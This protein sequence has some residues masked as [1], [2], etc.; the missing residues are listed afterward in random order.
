MVILSFLLGC[1]PKAIYFP[2]L[3]LMLFVPK[4][5]FGT[6]Y[7]TK[8]LAYRAA[9]LGASAL[10]LASFAAPFLFGSSGSGD[11]RGGDGVDS[12]GQV[13]WILENPLSFVSIMGSFLK[14]YLSPSVSGGY[15]DSLAYLS[16][17][18]LGGVPLVVLIIASIVDSNEKAFLYSGAR[19]KIAAFLLLLGTSFLMATALY[20][21][22]TPVG[23]STVNGCQLRYLLPLVIPFLMLALNLK[24]TFLGSRRALAGT[25]LSLMVFFD[26][27]MYCSAVVSL[28][29]I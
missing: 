13:R 1:A 17:S 26:F 7:K 10:L 2:I 5:F 21:S 15:T 8:S 6:S 12:M 4:R 16:P 14:D 24:V 20:I 23:L 22:F 19:Y 9:V 3:F 29:T 18:L 11:S 25:A 27:W 28:Y